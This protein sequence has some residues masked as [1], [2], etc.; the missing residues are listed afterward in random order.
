MIET[1]WPDPR[2]DMS[3]AAA[4]PDILFA[5][6]AD[7]R[8]GSDREVLASWG[9][10]FNGEPWMLLIPAVEPLRETVIAIATEPEVVRLSAAPRPT[11]IQVIGLTMPDGPVLLFL[12]ELYDELQAPMAFDSPINPCAPEGRELVSS[13]AEQETLQLVFYDQHDG[14]PIGRRVLRFE[15]HARFTAR[16]LLQA[17]VDATSD[18]V[19]WAQAAADARRWLDGQ[20]SRGIV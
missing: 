18:P 9:G 3:Y 16:Q 20:R 10:E 17:S 12:V 2:L 7:S 6:D 13:L 19:R 14:R 8:A 15:A 4:V 11:G 5:M 1:T